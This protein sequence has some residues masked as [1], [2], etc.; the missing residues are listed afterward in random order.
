MIS[1]GMWDVQLSTRGRQMLQRE[2]F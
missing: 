2:A 1:T